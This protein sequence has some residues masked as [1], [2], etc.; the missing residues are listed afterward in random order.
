MMVAWALDLVT[1]EERAD[2]DASM[3]DAQDIYNAIISIIYTIVSYV[4]EEA[5]TGDLGLWEC[6]Y[7]LLV[8]MRSLK[9]RPDLLK[10]FSWAFHAEL[11]VPFLN[12][13]LREDETRGGGAWESAS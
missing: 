8:F 6:I 1:P 7:V 3:A 9:T 11:L 12:M 5:D 2:L 13:L 10:L 4:L